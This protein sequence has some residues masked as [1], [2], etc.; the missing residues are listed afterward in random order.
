MRGRHRR[1]RA[2][3]FPRGLLKAQ[4]S[5][6]M[7]TVGTLT[8]PTIG[9]ERHMATLRQAFEH[10]TPVV[11]RVPHRRADCLSLQSEIINHE[12]QRSRGSVH[13]KAGRSTETLEQL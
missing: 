10:R 12:A 9:R 1:I 5:A 2:F 13:A 8:P 4:S 7:P 6:L 11:L 3:R